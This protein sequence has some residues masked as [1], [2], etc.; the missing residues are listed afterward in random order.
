[1]LYYPYHGKILT[2]LPTWVCLR[3]SC[4]PQN[5]FA[6]QTLSQSLTTQ[7]FGRAGSLFIFPRKGTETKVDG[8]GS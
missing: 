4:A 2:I 8:M 7:G 3:D 5:Q 6:P 1:M